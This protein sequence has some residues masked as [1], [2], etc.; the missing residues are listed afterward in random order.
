MS[1]VEMAVID[2]ALVEELGELLGFEA[3]LLERY[4]VQVEGGG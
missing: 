4:R 3:E 2:A 1:W